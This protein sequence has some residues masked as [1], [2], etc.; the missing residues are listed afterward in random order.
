MYIVYNS[1][2][3]KNKWSIQRTSNVNIYNTYT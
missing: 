3:E 2:N 1:T